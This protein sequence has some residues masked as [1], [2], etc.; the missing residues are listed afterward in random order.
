MLFNSK[1][2]LFGK[3]SIVDLIVII[4]VVI[5]LA[6]AYV[7][8]SGKDVVV[9]QESAEFYYTLK[10]SEIRETN[11][12]YLK[13]SVGTEFFRNGDENY[14]M[15]VLED[16]QVKE[17]VTTINMNDGSVVSATIPEK[18]D[19]LLT[20]KVNGF[21]KNDGYYT[22]DMWEINVGRTYNV[23]NIYCSVSGI[24]EKIWK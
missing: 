2:K 6:G 17:A 9:T 24:A 4:L 12:N 22:P 13:K 1:G 7:R 23:C 16:V 20:F 19:V 15:G 5:A 10:V 14:P 11:M 3:V 8:L 21:E 18:Y